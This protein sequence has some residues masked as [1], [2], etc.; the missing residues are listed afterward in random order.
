MQRCVSSGVQAQK[1]HHS[2]YESREFSNT[3]WKIHY[4]YSIYLCSAWVIC[5]VVYN[6]SSLRIVAITCHLH[7]YDDDILAPFDT[8]ARGRMNYLRSL[9]LLQ[10]LHVNV[11]QHSNVHEW[12]IGQKCWVSYRQTTSWIFWAERR[13][14][15]VCASKMN[16]DSLTWAHN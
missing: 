6:I 7:L 2:V 4:L 5:N 16:A 15:W 10:T 13:A 3:I 12:Q 1:Y 9:V 14:F 8:K 11:V